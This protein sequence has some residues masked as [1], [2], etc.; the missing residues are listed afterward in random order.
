MATGMLGHLAHAWGRESLLYTP[1]VVFNSGS[2][3]P[4]LEPNNIGPF[5]KG[6]GLALK[7]VFGCFN[8]RF[9][10]GLFDGP[11]AMNALSELKWCH[12]VSDGDISGKFMIQKIR[13]SSVDGLFLLG[14]PSHVA[15]LVVALVVDA[16]Q[17][18]LCAWAGTDMS[19]ERREIMDPC[20]THPNASAAIASV[21]LVSDAETSLFH[22]G[23]C[24]VF[25]H[26]DTSFHVTNFTKKER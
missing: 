21:G 6:V 23:P 20:V 5:L 4:V 13:R 2:K 25:R 17:R 22:L 24:A 14:G 3:R 10:R 7:D 19:E 8:E 18:M 11:T 1:S 16:I 12:S 9:A 15:W 26:V